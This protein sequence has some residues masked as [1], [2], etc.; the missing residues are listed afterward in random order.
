MQSRD[1]HLTWAKARALALCDEGKLVE[2][3]SSYMSDVLNHPELRNHA[4]IVLGT[5]LAMNGHLDT[6]EAVRQWI[7]GLQ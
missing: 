1:E 5:M 4:S 7:D 6:V 3:L 2:A